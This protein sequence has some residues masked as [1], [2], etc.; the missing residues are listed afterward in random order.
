MRRRGSR[1]K[2]DEL[3]FTVPQSLLPPGGLDRVV[4]FVESQVR[5][6]TAMKRIGGRNRRVGFYSSVGCKGNQRSIQVTFI[7]ESGSTPNRW[8]KPC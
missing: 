1:A 4:Q 2:S 3:R 8:N 5:K 6:R 7:D